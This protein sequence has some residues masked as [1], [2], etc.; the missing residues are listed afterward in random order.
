MGPI[1]DQA[2]PVQDENAQGDQ[3]RD[4]GRA[5]DEIEMDRDT[6]QGSLQNQDC[7]SRTPE[8]LWVATI[9][10]PLFWGLHADTRRHTTRALNPIHGM[11]PSLHQALPEPGQNQDQDQRLGID[12]GVDTQAKEGEGEVEHLCSLFLGASY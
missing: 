4:L 2:E 11:E 6:K 1:L 12:T 3:A 7:L 5:Q 8:S 9:I 10:A